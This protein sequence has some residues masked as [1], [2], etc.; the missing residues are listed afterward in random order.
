MTNFPPVLYRGSVKN[1]RGEVSAPYLIFE[2]SDRFSVFDWGEMPDQLED[3]GKTLAIMGK[4]FFKYLGTPQSWNSIFESKILRDNFDESYLNELSRSPIYQKLK[5]VGLIHHALLNDEEISWSS[6]YLKVK[7][8]SVIRPHFDGVNY[9]Y[10]AYNE[11]PVNALVPLEIIFRLGLPP[12]NSLTK[13]LGNDLS[14]WAEFGFS[15]VPQ[16]GLLQKTI[17]DFSTKLES[18]DR[19]IDYSEAQK[20]ASMNDEEFYELKTMTELIALSLFKFHGEMGLTLLDGKIEMAFVE[21]KNKKRSF[22]LVDSIGIDEL[23]LLYKGRSFS[24]EF[25]REFYKKSSWYDNLEAAKK[26]AQIHG[27]DFKSLCIEK[28][29]STPMPLDK[30]TKARAE[31]VYKSYANEVLKKLGEE[32]VFSADFNLSEYCSRY[33]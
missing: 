27:G 31:S 11:K 5:N 26:D 22:M 19:Y 17:V 24:K 9:Q 4:S 23:R 18:G 12:G 29:Q 32:P 16:N 14:K 2:F 10:E 33:Q 28:Y 21:D 30:L 6:P 1:V 25:L 15:E 3:K 7:N 20:I 13:R 8:V